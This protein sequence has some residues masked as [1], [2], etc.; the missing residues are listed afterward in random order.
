M[1]KRLRNLPKIKL[2]FNQKFRLKRSL[3]RYHKKLVQ[4]RH[5]SFR[6][7]KCQSNRFSFHHNTKTLIHGN[8]KLSRFNPL[9][10]TS[11]LNLQILTN[12]FTILSLQTNFVK[13]PKSLFRSFKSFRRI[14][15][16]NRFYTAWIRREKSRIQKKWK[17]RN[18]KISNLTH[19]SRR[20]KEVGR[21]RW[22]KGGLK[23][24]LRSRCEKGKRS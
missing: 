9:S 3:V 12:S 14:R 6:S 17:Y 18:S 5:N 24:R 16:S 20:E 4:L 23:R 13:N 15:Q 22:L 11:H 10:C 19:R 21:R 7:I 8:F 2:K 1:K